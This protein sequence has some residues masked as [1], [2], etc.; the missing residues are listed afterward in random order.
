VLNIPKL[1][2]SLAG[3]RYPALVEAKIDGEFAFLDY[4][5]GLI[6]TQS[7]YGTSRNDLSLF[8]VLETAFKENGVEQ[9]TLLVEICWERGLKGSFYKLLENKSSKDL[10]I[11]PHDILFLNEKDLRDRPL[12]DRKEILYETI[13]ELQLPTRLVENK[14]E[15]EKWFKI[16]TDKGYEGIVLKSLDSPLVLGPCSWVKMKVKDRND[17]QVALVDVKERIAVIA[18]LPTNGSNTYVGVKAPNRY[19]KH[20]KVGDM[21]TIEH[22]GILKSGSLRHPVLIPKKEWL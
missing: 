9:C 17:Y 10:M 3:L 5:K 4:D 6:T 12:V 22:Q 7:Q 11:M 18:S 13:G 19:K 1:R 16:V 2:G 14:E 20:I 15:V 21:V 8:S